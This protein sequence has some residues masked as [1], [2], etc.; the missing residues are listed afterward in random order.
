MNK[1]GMNRFIRLVC[2]ILVAAY[3]FISTGA[4]PTPIPSKYT[5]KI[6]YGAD[7]TL[8]VGQST[9]LTVAYKLNKGQT[10][11]SPP[12]FSFQATNGTVSPDTSDPGAA[13][14][15][16]VYFTFTATEAGDAALFAQAN[17][18]DGSDM[19][20]IPVEK[21]CQ[22][23]YNLIITLQATSS[24]GGVILKWM[25]VIKSK[26][27]FTP[28]PAGLAPLAPLTPNGK[29]D[30]L[31][32]I[33]DEELPQQ[34]ECNVPATEWTG[35]D[36]SGTAIVSGQVLG[37]GP[38]AG[39]VID[40]NSVAMKHDPSFATPCKH[41]KVGQKLPMDFSADSWIHEQFPAWGGSR[42]IRI[43]ML[44]NGVKALNKSPGTSASYTAVLTVE[45]LK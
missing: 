38:Q 16:F 11:K 45:R 26:G 1:L 30:A 10:E 36:G 6:Y 19:T 18:G 7:K 43:E 3:L 2:P 33:F 29:L 22:Y 8:C 24:N 13:G 31:L 28:V 37:G 44:E 12:R 42:Q 5:V 39:V 21:D 15:G 35:L 23:S 14:S 32:T 34:D 25:D 4:A 20:T 27:T 40:F 9:T 17:Q 41:G